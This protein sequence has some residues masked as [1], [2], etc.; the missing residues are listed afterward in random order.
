MFYETQ[1]SSGWLLHNVEIEWK[2]AKGS[3]WEWEAV[4]LWVQSLMC[5]HKIFDLL[6]V[7]AEWG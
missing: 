3:Q 4:A 7:N 2:K 1:H 6:V 5:L